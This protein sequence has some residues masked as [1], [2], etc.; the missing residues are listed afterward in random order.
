M[1]P[2]PTTQA[3]ALK[4]VAAGGSAAAGRLM[5]DWLAARLAGSSSTNVQLKVRKTLCRPRS[6]ANFSRL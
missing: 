2:R 6:W 1:R 5:A 3:R 4:T